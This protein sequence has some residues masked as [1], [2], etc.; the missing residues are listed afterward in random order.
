MFASASAHVCVCVCMRAGVRVLHVQCNYENLHFLPTIHKHTL[1]GEITLL[2]VSNSLCM[3][4]HSHTHTCTR[5]SHSLDHKHSSNLSLPQALRVIHPF[6]TLSP[7]LSHSPTYFC[8]KCGRGHTHT[9][10]HTLSQ[11]SSLVLSFSFKGLDTS[12][13]CAESLTVGVGPQHPGA[14]GAVGGGGEGRSIVL[15][16]HKRAKF[17]SCL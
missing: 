8:T 16:T 4:R 17:I 3:H 1:I 7:S 15:R 5:I 13:R 14:G 12:R 9:R 11:F 6:S 10:S 2:S